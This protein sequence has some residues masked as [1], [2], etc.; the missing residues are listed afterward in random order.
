MGEIMEGAQIR[1]A[2]EGFKAKGLK[3]DLTRGKPSSAQ[4]DLS[5]ELLT[6]PGPAD[7]VAEGDIDCR[8]Y[9]VLQG[10]PEARRL[11]SGMMG[12]EPEQVVVANNSSLALMH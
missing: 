11:F 10:L 3:L 2:L 1:S 6:L 4:L 12:A 5:T 7:Y 9:G 8:N